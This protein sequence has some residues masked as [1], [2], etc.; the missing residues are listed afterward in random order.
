MSAEAQT[1][2]EIGRGLVVIAMAAAAAAKSLDV[3][4]F[5][6]DIGR[7]F[8]WLRG[9]SARAIAFAI[10]A[11]EWMIVIL[12]MVGSDMAQIGLLAALVLLTGF[13]AVVAWSVIF[14]RGLV[15]SCFG[16]SSSHR[17]NG[18][19]L[20][21]NLLLMAAAAFAWQHAPAQDVVHT[22][23][24]QPLFFSIA[25]A[26]CAAT[27]FILITSLQDIALLLRIDTGR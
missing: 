9:A 8:A 6:H 26:T 19:D 1:L 20:M 22:I 14:D 27:V 2:A 10:L 25:T 18:Y 12:I 24:T 11:A 21:R 17:M 15:C 7:S 23:S 4:G 3:N 16:A 13:T 5:A